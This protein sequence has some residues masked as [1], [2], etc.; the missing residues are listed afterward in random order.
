[1]QLGGVESI[2][3]AAQEVLAS[4]ESAKAAADQFVGTPTLEQAD[5]T[6]KV[7]E[8]ALARLTHF[9]TTFHSA[10]ELESISGLRLTHLLG[11]FTSP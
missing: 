7:D 3:Q 8:G 11:P 2:S 10:P 6:R 4:V 1:M 5:S 9:K